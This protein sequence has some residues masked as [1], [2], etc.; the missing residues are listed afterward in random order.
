[1]PRPALSTFARRH[2]LS[3]RV[4]DATKA[5]IEAVACQAGVTASTAIE[6]LTAL[7][8]DAL[9]AGLAPGDHVEL[10]RPDGA[11]EVRLC[12]ARDCGDALDVLRSLLE[13]WESPDWPMPAD[14]PTPDFRLPAQRIFH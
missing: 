5:K 14:A 9:T 11:T 2:A 10:A 13:I 3:L 1:M 4:D 6:R 7:G 12:L 8:F